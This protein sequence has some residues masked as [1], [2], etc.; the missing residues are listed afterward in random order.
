MQG[1]MRLVCDTSSII[2]QLLCKV[3]KCLPSGHISVFWVEALVSGGVIKFAKPVHGHIGYSSVRQQKAVHCALC[4]QFPAVNRHTF[5][6]NCSHC[7]SNCLVRLLVL[8]LF[9]PFLRACS[10]ANRDDQ[11]C[12]YGQ[13]LQKLIPT[14][15]QLKTNYQYST[16]IAPLA[17]LVNG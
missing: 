7:W 1:E 16:T 13:S 9:Q 17:M 8:W 5:G 2:S 14:F 15:L 12:E 3:K 11:L 6:N 10:I 4:G